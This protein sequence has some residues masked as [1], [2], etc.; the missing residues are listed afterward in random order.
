MPSLEGQSEAV[1]FGELPR[2]RSSRSAIGG[3][4]RLTLRK[5]TRAWAAHYSI[6]LA[7]AKRSSLRRFARTFGKERTEMIDLNTHVLSKRYRRPASQSIEVAPIAMFQLVST[8]Q[9]G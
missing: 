3:N 6:I 2:S 4:G 1:S 7:S 8:A 5:L 9:F